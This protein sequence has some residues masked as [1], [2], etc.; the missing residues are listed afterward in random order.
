MGRLSSNILIFFRVQETMARRLPPSKTMRRLS[1]FFI[2]IFFLIAIRGSAEEVFTYPGFGDLHVYQPK[3]HHA[4][5]FLILVSGD[6]GWQRAAPVVAEA[7]SRE[8]SFVAGVEIKKYLRGIK[9][10]SGCVSVAED[11]HR[12]AEF[13]RTRYQLTQKKPVLF[14]YSSGATLVYAALAQSSPGE[15]RGAL[16]FGFCTDFEPAVDFCKG[17]GLEYTTGS[18]HNGVVLLPS[19]AIQDP[20][21][22][23]QGATDVVCNPQKTEDFTNQVSTGEFVLIPKAGHGFAHLNGWMPEFRRVWTR[24]HAENSDISAF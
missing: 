21:V 24:F 4:R 15:F 20:W 18:V 22:T 12:L 17:N 8:G 23:F 5:D 14:G 2:S 19:K 3:D 13:L 1:V 7:L 16:S 11:F 6:G 10:N 9:R